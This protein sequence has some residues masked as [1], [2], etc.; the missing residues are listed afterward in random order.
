ML[1][2]NGFQENATVFP[3]EPLKETEPGFVV[4]GGPILS[5]RWFISGVFELNRY[6][7]KSD[8]ENLLVPTTGFLATDTAAA[9]NGAAHR[10]R[11]ACFELQQTADHH[12]CE[13]AGRHQSLAGRA[14]I[15]LFTPRRRGSIHVPRRLSTESTAD[16]SAGRPI[17]AF[18]TPLT[19][20]ANSFEGRVASIFQFVADERSSRRILHRSDRL[21]SPAS[22]VP[23]LVHRRYRRRNVV[24]PGSPLPYSFENRGRN[25]E[26][27]DNVIWTRGRH[28][29][30]VGGGFLARA[31]S[32]DMSPPV[33][34]ES[35]ISP[36]SAASRSDQAD[37]FAIARTR[38][39][40]DRESLAG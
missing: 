32:P 2:A 12:L 27:V 5:N 34:T 21:Q 7:T 23:L 22:G 9:P 14:A 35:S 40:P 17:P 37:L 36:I 1:D 30:T 19:Q 33:R 13:S 29:F 3:R 15:G 10:I 28:V 8:P 18:V 24:L 39:N 20:G 25:F 16:F 38:Q 11:A 31:L 4:A 26:L 6:R